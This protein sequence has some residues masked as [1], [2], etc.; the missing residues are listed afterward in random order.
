VGEVQ[1]GGLPTG[2]ADLD[3]LLPSSGIPRGRLTELLGVRG[4]GR[5]T[6]LRRIVRNVVN[7]GFWVAYIDATRTLAPAQWAGIGRGDRLW[8]VRPPAGDNA[9]GAW[10]ADVLLRSGAFALVVLDGAPVLNRS[11]A[12][13]LSRLAR[14][15]NSA[16][17]VTGDERSAT[18]LGGALRLRLRRTTPRMR[19]RRRRWRGALAR[20]RWFSIAIEKGG[21]PRSVEV[22]CAVG[23]E[24]RLCTYPEIPDRRG[25]ARRTRGKWGT[26]VTAG[27]YATLG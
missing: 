25:V 18:M 1:T 11:I 5:T 7:A 2:I 26:T 16:F 14:D 4:V 24:S 27:R 9:R 3:S 17:V 22:C 12:V 8:V 15:S 6:L 23:V 20:D 10:C 21:S 13:R 19:G